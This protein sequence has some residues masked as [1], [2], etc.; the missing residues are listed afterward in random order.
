M[1]TTL[2]RATDDADE[3]AIASGMCFAEERETAEAYRDDPGFGGE[4]IRVAD[5]ELDAVLDIT[6]DG[7][8]RLD[9]LAAALGYDAPHDIA[10]DWM[11]SGWRYPW[12]ESRSVSERLRESGYQWLRYVDDYPEGAVTLMRI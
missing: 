4:H 1:T 11:L 9:T 8:R 6:A 7:G 12:E 2:Y 3:T 10:Q 5:V